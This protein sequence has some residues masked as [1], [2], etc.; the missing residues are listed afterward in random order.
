MCAVPLRAGV[1]C[2]N[3]CGRAGARS[4]VDYSLCS[5]VMGSSL[6]AR[7]AG[8]KP[9]TK[10]TTIEKTTAMNAASGGVESFQPS[11]GSMM[12]AP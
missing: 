6:A 10:P 11:N 4:A 9:K 8:K 12:A 2:R 1:V 7:H 5:A 3:Y